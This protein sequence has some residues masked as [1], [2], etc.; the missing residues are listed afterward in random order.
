MSNIIL[1][2]GR[3]LGK[4][5]GSCLDIYINS[6]ILLIPLSFPVIVWFR[7]RSSDRISPQTPCFHGQ[8]KAVITCLPHR[9][10]FAPLDIKR[11]GCLSRSLICFLKV[12]VKLCSWTWRIQ[13]EFEKTL[14]I[15]RSHRRRHARAVINPP[16]HSI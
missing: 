11:H 13:L 15:R 7:S 3:W 2:L 10:D 1:F 9:R 6:Y 8:C 14:F 16:R 12:S 5:H 4:N